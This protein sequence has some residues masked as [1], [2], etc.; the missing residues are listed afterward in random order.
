[1]NQAD[2]DALDPAAIQRELMN[3]DAELEEMREPYMESVRT[4]ENAKAEMA[5]NKAKMQ[6]INSRRSTLQSVLRTL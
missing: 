3:L 1:M 5:G 2:R 4:A 6:F